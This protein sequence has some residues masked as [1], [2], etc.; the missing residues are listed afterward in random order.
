[1]SEVA[2]YGAF[3]CD[4]LS[5]ALP[6]QALREAVPLADCVA[7]PCAAPFV[8]GGLPLRG[9]V[10]PL[11]DVALALGLSTQPAPRPQALVVGHQGR[12]LALA[13]DAIDGV[14]T[15]PAAAMDVAPGLYA[16]SVRRDDSGA[17]L[18]LLSMAALFALPGLATVPEQRALDAPSTAARSRPMV[19]LRCGELR[20]ALDA[21]QVQATL[22]GPELR[23]SAL[24]RGVCRGEIAHAGRLVAAVDLHALCGFGPAPEPGP[25][26]PPR[27]AVTLALPNGL[28]ALLVD[29][30]EDVRHVREAQRVPLSPLGLPEPALF[31]A[32]LCG[33]AAA[34]GL[35]DDGAPH[36]CLSI[37]A[38]RRHPA[39][40]A[41]AGLQRPAGS[42]VRAG[43]PAAAQAARGE[44]PVQRLV[45]FELGGE[46]AVPIESLVEILRCP[47][48]FNAFGLA[49]RATGVM[50][51][52]GRAIPVL[53]LGAMAGV[54][55]VALGPD[56][57]VLVVAQDGVFAGFAVSALKSIE[58]CRWTPDADAQRLAAGDRRLS[59]LGVRRHAL[60][61]EAS[62]QRLVPVLDLQALAQ[63]LLSPV[64]AAA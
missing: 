4:R 48:G 9:E 5:L 18:Q 49:G 45:T 19:L 44:G 59:A 34:D 50:V 64:P 26:Q 47:A 11:V 6:V 38:L 43:T 51:S 30:V 7:L 14:F 61:G 22:A 55:A 35:A 10:L 58:P 12:L 8:V 28:V 40:V 27:P 39:L 23:V 13:V 53:D 46:C 3:H 42:E 20:L 21:L 52:R 54:E 25:L 56:A 33:D 57:R 17:L 29:A 36:L 62:A 31:E 15:A 63:G 32:A 2:R 41:L 16:G 1:M 37:E 24:A 60:L